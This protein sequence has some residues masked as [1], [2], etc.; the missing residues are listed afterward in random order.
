[1][2]WAGQELHGFGVAK[3]DHIARILDGAKTAATDIGQ[4]GLG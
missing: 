3:S 4:T 1:M 2:A